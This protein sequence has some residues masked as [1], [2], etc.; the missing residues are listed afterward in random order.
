MTDIQAAVLPKAIKGVDIVAAAKT[1][2]GKTL[3]FLIPAIELTNRVLDI[4]GTCT[5]IIS[6]TRE[7]AMQTYN[8]LQQLVVLNKNITCALLIGGESKKKQAMDLA[9]GAKIIVATPGR[10][11]DH[12]RSKEFVFANLKCL[13][14]DE[15]DKILQYG[16]EEDL[17]QI[18][19]LLPDNHIIVVT[20]GLNTIY[21]I[22]DI[23]YIL[24]WSVDYPNVAYL[25][26]SSGG[27]TPP[28]L[29]VPRSRHSRCSFRE[30]VATRSLDIVLGKMNQME[31]TKTMQDFYSAKTGTLFCTDV[32]ARGLDIPAVDWIVQ[33]DPPGDTSEYIHRVG[34]TA[35]GIGGIGNAVLLLRHEEKGFLKYL[36]EAKIYVE[37]YKM[38]D[39]YENHQPMLENIIENNNHFKELAIEAYESYIRAFEVRKLKDVF[40]LMALDLDVLA[41]SYGLKEKP[42]VDIRIGFKKK[43]RARKRIAALLENN[44]NA[45][46]SIKL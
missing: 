18:M 26:S 7:L 31:R 13:V 12:M 3:A 6:P 45:P 44:T 33:F 19:N 15:A 4:K 30:F 23:D 40:N 20:F 27:S 16:F 24:Q 32:A 2:S 42:E 22:A 10:L 29:R 28:V 36:Q 25:N 35:R 11:L 38:W 5:I 39:D 43:H 37:L 14:L 41:K 1:G 8:V 9:K 34:R 21:I 46:K 17:K